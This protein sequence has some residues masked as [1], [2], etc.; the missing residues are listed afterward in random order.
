MMDF[1]F[2]TCF[3]PSDE[4]FDD[5]SYQ[6]YEN[7]SNFDMYEQY[8]QAQLNGT[9]TGNYTTYYATYS[10]DGLVFARSSQEGRFTAVDQ[11]EVD[12]FTEDQI[13]FHEGC[14]V[15][16][17]VMIARLRPKI[18]TYTIMAALPFIL[19]IAMCIK[20]EKYFEKKEDLD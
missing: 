19:A 20:V 9:F 13:I 4:Q 11:D 12:G 1:W 17:G 16:Y 18:D 8:K 7:L 5:Q 14:A 2:Q 3:I 15:R 10:V 6:V